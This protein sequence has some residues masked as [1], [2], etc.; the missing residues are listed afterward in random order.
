[1]LGRAIVLRAVAIGAA[2]VADDVTTSVVCSK[3]SDFV[4]GDQ[5]G[6]ALRPDGTLTCWGDDT[7]GQRSAPEGKYHQLTAGTWFTC[8]LRD[9]DD[10][11]ACWGVIVR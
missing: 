2:N 8:A 3:L 11:E 5:H 6:C 1:M 7:Y 9:S 10:S 4:F